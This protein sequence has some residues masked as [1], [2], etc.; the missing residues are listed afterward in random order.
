MLIRL[1]DMNEKIIECIVNQNM[2]WTNIVVAI[3]SVLNIFAVIYIFIS[4]KK[5]NSKK[6]E[7]NNKKSWYTMFGVQEKTVELSNII[8]DLKEK[9]FKFY[10]SEIEQN[11]LKEE[12]KMVENELL[13]YK[14]DFLTITDCIDPNVTIRLT[15]EFNNIQDYIYRLLI[16]Y[17]GDKNAD[18]RVSQQEI[19]INIDDI[20]KKI[21][22]ISLKII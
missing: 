9:I 5:A 8:N 4:E 15:N 6:E 16:K 12:F 7:K 17:I 11:D 20:R 13:K 22:K 14:N 21:I 18:C 1:Y 19:V 10:N 3:T 2:D